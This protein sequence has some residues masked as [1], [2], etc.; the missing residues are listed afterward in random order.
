MQS[1]KIL[2]DGGIKV[3]SETGARNNSGW[4]VEVF[5]RPAECQVKF[6][7]L[8]KQWIVERPFSW[9]ENFRRLTIDF[10]DLAETDEAIVQLAFVQI[11][12]NKFIQCF[13]NS[14]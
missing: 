11:M 8:P 12:L 1:T 2:A 13:Q 14:F 3:L 9:L 6:P 5:L 7:V 4:V 10:E